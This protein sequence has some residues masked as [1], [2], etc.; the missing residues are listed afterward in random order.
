MTERK[1]GGDAYKI[2]FGSLTGQREQGAA[3]IERRSGTS[4]VAFTPEN[5]IDT[6]CSTPSGE[7]P[8]T[9]PIRVLNEWNYL[10]RNAEHVKD[11]SA[12]TMLAVKAAS[13]KENIR[14]IKT[15]YEILAYP[16]CRQH[17]NSGELIQEDLEE[18]RQSFGR[19]QVLL[20]DIELKILGR[21]AVTK[22]IPFDPQKRIYSYKEVPIPLHIDPYG[23]RHMTTD[24]IRNWLYK[25][26]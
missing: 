17:V 18:D 13:V 4:L 7:D 2:S 6:L 25:P 21:L 9:W 14:K 5:M 8:I 23:R 16:H 1:V 20:N 12:S 24:K 11:N 15:A 10:G 26:V 19:D 3:N 22:Q